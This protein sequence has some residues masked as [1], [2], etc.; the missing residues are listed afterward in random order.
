MALFISYNFVLTLNIL[1]SPDRKPLED[2]IKTENLPA[3]TN[4][5]EDTK[6]PPL[7]KAKSKSKVSKRILYYAYIKVKFSSFLK[8][9]E[10]SSKRRSSKELSSAS[11]R[12]RIK[13]ISSDSSS[14]ESA[15]E[16]LNGKHS[17]EIC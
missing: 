9:K 6:K 14:E 8:T 15:P 2:Q 13:E 12:R 3:E 16:G 10:S 4:N 1:Q 5:S 11:K 7:K 17:F